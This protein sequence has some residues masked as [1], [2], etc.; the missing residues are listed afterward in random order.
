ML[1][2]RQ[3][4]IEAAIGAAEKSGALV[5]Y[6]VPL[7]EG[8]HDFRALWLRTELDSL[9][10][11]DRLEP[12]Q[13]HRVKAALKRFVVGGPF[14]VVTAECPHRGVS[15]LGDLRELRGNRPPF[16]EMRFKP[17]KHDLRFFGRFIR[18]DG[19]ILTTHGLK[20]LDSVTGTR[21]L[22][23]SD[24]RRRCDDFFAMQ[25]FQLDWVPVPIQSSITHA[26]FV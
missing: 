18:K 3:A 15:T 13:R 22:V 19:L 26:T 25:R 4:A 10:R 11:S 14:N 16:I 17:P 12:D 20:S 6:R 1:S 21:P 24:E 2:A 5:R 7:E 23:V 9:L 8:E